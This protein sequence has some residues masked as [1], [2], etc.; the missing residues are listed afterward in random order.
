MKSN[1]L[2]IGLPM[3]VAA[4]ALASAAGT[5]SLRADKS[6]LVPGYARL[7]PTSACSYVA[8]CDD[9][10]NVICTAPDDDSIVLHGD[11]NNCSNT[12]LKKFD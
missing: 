8:D 12:P 11:P 3:A 7:T 10:G 4:F 5:S 6:A 1:V 9:N 2:K